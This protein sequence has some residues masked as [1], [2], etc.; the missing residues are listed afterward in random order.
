MVLGRVES[1]KVDGLTALRIEEAENRTKVILRKMEHLLHQHSSESWLFA[2]S[3]PTAL[4]A[5]LIIFIARLFDIGRKDL[6]PERLLEYGEM[7]CKTQ[8][9]DQVMQ[10]RRTVMR[11]I[12]EP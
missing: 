8:E 12:T 6:I 2:S 4:D 5:H 3:S 1:E 7:A 9:W 10:D 11:Q